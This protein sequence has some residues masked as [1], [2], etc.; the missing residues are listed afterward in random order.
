MR[1]SFVHVY[2]RAVALSCERSSTYQVWSVNLIVSTTVNLWPLVR[3]KVKKCSWQQNSL[4][5]IDWNLCSFFFWLII[6]LDD[7]LWHF[8]QCFSTS[9][10]MLCA[11]FLFW[12][13]FSLELLF[14]NLCQTRLRDL[15]RDRLFHDDFVRLLSLVCWPGLLVWAHSS[16]Y[17][18]SLSFPSL[19][20]LRT[21]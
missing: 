19:T 1:Y 21:V 7:E 8:W 12:W 5:H 11:V 13:H 9:G 3:R 6:G 18:F 16:D 14:T 17:T 15:G 20:H 4:I 2:G 10:C